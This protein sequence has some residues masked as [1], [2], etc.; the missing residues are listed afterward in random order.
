MDPKYS[1]DGNQVARL[2]T[3]NSS[4]GVRMYQPFFPEIRVLNASI[5]DFSNY[6]AK[7]GLAIQKFVFF[8]ESWIWLFPLSLIL[9]HRRN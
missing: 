8:I 1:K 7:R 5:R 4:E 9:I 2:L 3:K 6:T